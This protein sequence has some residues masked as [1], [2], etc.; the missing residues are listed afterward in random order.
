MRLIAAM[1]FAAV[2]G[3]SAP[4]AAQDINGFFGRLGG[5]WSG[6]GTVKTDPA[7]AAGATTCRLSGTPAGQQVTITGSCDGAA[8]GAQLSVVLRYSDATRDFVGTF[9][10]GTERGTASLSGRLTGNTLSMRV[11]SESGE[12]SLLALT[13]VGAEQIALKVSGKDKGGKTV[14][15]VSLALRK[16]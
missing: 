4:A 3:L 1:A 8:Q 12:T 9:Q 5:A 16:S 15:Y 14:D 2:V 6:S 10:G 13:F 11:T 7:A